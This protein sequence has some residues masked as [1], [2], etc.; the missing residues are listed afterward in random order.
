M[1]KVTAPE[2]ESSWPSSLR[3]LALIMM[4]ILKL[5]SFGRIIWI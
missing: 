5:N 1:D 4:T 2:K 3:S